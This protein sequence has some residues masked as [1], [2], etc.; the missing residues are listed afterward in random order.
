MWEQALVFV[1]VV[2]CINGRIDYREA[3]WSDDDVK[4][5]CVKQCKDY[6]TC[7]TPMKC[8]EN[9]I[10]CGEAYLKHQPHCP[11]DEICSPDSCFCKFTTKCFTN[12]I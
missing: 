2:Q 1:M 12:M 4:Q 11:P 5:N 3:K 9:E 8:N 7:A 10:K 6:C